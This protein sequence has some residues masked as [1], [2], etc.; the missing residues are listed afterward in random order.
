[1]GRSLRVRV[2]LMAL[3]APT[4]CLSFAVSGVAGAS[5]PKAAAKVDVTCTKLTA[6]ESGSGTISGCTSTADTSGGGKIKAD[7][8]TSTGTIT[9]GKS[10]GTT[11]TSFTYSSPAKNKCPK[12]STEIIETSTVTSSTGKADKVIKVGN[13]GTTDICLSSAG[14]VSLL[15]G[16]KYEV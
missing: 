15:K 6:N 13:V 14:K 8:S 2:A 16:S 5:T 1:V 7:I 12:G 9:W 11:V 3:V 4:L 10:D